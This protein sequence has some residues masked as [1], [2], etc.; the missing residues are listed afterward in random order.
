MAGA[1][2]ASY[3]CKPAGPTGSTAIRRTLRYTVRTAWVPGLWQPAHRG[4]RRWTLMRLRLLWPRHAAA[5]R[6][7]APSR[8]QDKLPRTVPGR[9]R[10][11]GPEQPAGGTRNR[12]QWATLRSR[13]QYLGR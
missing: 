1:L 6:L 4:R 13:M 8:A 3:T 10:R 2:T 9:C 5:P 7:L 11:G 12:D